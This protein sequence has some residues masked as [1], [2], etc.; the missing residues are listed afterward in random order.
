MTVPSGLMN[1]NAYLST[2]IGKLIQE[3]IIFMRFYCCFKLSK[4]TEKVSNEQPTHAIIKCTLTDL[5]QQA[6]KSH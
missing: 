4:K 1:V 6:K 3:N 2:H 5:V